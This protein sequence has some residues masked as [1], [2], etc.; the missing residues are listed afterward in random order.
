MKSQAEEKILE[1]LDTLVKYGM[2]ASLGQHGG[3]G[4]RDYEKRRLDRIM[5]TIMIARDRVVKEL[6]S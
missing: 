1:T 3:P 6:E 5:K 2:E 4:T